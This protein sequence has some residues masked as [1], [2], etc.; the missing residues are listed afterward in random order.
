M[1]TDREI[2]AWRDGYT[3]GQ[4]DEAEDA[5]K[6]IAEERALAFE[7]G[8]V[9]GAAIVAMFEAIRKIPL[10]PCGM[11][12][13]KGYTLRAG[14]GGGVIEKRCTYCRKGYAPQEER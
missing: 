8:L 1:P 5:V 10:V 4:A 13:A 9:W 11:C 14:F 3:S 2:E 7:A 6:L 12:D